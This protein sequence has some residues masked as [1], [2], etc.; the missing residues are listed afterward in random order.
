MTGFSGKAGPYLDKIVMRV[1]KDPSARAIA[2]EN[3]EL[4]LS[5]FESLARNINRLKKVESLTTTSDGYAAIGPLDWL[6]FNTASGKTADVRVRQA[7]AYAIDRNFI[8][9]A[10]LLGTA[11]EARTGIHPGSPLYE[12]DG[13]LLRC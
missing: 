5:T 4:H 11:D 9:K 10:I 3:G 6:A 13:C 2:L 12:A 7:I 8:L 1:I